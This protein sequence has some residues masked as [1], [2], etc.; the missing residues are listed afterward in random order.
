[1]AAPKEVISTDKCE[2]LKLG[3]SPF[4]GGV[5][6]RAFSLPPVIRTIG[7]DGRSPAYEE[8]HASAKSP[9]DHA[10]MG[11]STGPRFRVARASAAAIVRFP[12]NGEFGYGRFHIGSFNAGKSSSMNIAHP[13]IGIHLWAIW[14]GIVESDQPRT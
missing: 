9:R 7:A 11:K 14:V 6:E 4:T 5:A 8:D 10:T 3:G 2:F 13:V 1:M 12:R